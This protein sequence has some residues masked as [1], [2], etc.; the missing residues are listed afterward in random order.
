MG[1]ASRGRLSRRGARGE[2][3]VP[4]RSGR[5]R[6]RCSALAKPMRPEARARGPRGPSRRA[7][8]KGGRTRCR[9]LR[10]GVARPA[11]GLSRAL[12]FQAE[13]RLSETAQR[14]SPE[15][16]RGGGRVPRSAKAPGREGGE[17][18]LGPSRS[19]WGRC[20][21]SALA[22]TSRRSVLIVDRAAAWP[23][24]TRA[25]LPLNLGA[26]EPQLGVCQSSV[27]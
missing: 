16:A 14:G 19:G 6:C 17:C 20:R 5:G 2:R 21:R 26:L 23:A 13:V 18:D 7:K 22:G 10:P 12:S 11:S 1:I 15:G 9:A 3:V 24:L 27:P 4:S 8:N 25:A